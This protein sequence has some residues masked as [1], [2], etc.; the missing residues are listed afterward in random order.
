M[1]REDMVLEREQFSDPLTNTA[2][3]ARPFQI[4]IVE[5]SEFLRAA[6]IQAL[7]TL[8]NV[9]IVGEAIDAANA[10]NLIH[11]REPDLVLLDIRLYQSNGFQV[12]EHLQQ[13]DVKP[14]VMVLTNYG[15]PQYRQ[16]VLQ[17]GANYFFDKSTEF[18]VALQTIRDLVEGHSPQ[19]N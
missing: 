2:V 15:Y 19:V 1:I 3:R 17:A 18:D 7:T 10:V 5:D 13:A 11:Q 9:Q 6:I 16:R 4:L 12:L 14:V 8:P